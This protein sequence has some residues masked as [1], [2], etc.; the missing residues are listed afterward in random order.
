ML[1]PGSVLNDRYTIETLIAKGGMS[2]VYLASDS[3][4][5]G[6]IVVKEMGDIFP[7]AEDR[8]AIIGQFRRE[9]ALLSKLSHMSLPRV[10]D[11]FSIQ[12][13]HYLVEEHLEGVTLDKKA[14]LGLFSEEE[15]LGVAVQILSLLDFLH[16]H[17]IIYRDV[18]PHHIMACS[19]GTYRL[20][21]FGIARLFSIGKRRDTVL[22]GT[23]GFA[24]PEHYGQRQTDE[25]SDIYGMAATLHFLVTGKDS[26]LAPFHFDPPCIVN[27]AVSKWFSDI[28]MAGVELSPEDRFQSAREMLEVLSGPRDAPVRARNFCYPERLPVLRGK[29]GVCSVLFGFV[30]A[31]FLSSAIIEGNLAFIGVSL[32]SAAVSYGYLT[33]NLEKRRT[34]IVA[35]LRDLTLSRSG[36]NAFRT[37]IPWES[38]K[39]LRICRA[40]RWAGALR[41]IVS[42]GKEA[43]QS[44]AISRIEILYTIEEAGTSSERIYTSLSHASFD[45]AALL[46][47]G[48]I[49]KLSF[50]S[51]LEGW[52]EL[53]RFI[54]ARAKL[55]NADAPGSDV[56][57]EVYLR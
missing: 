2:L 22:M 32:F 21:D 41:K 4:L 56:L 36:Y 18:K 13:S 42:R 23:P 27:E 46:E 40:Q 24:A 49:K 20:V 10:I 3:H 43:R 57:D 50:T 11:S 16:S 14:A 1:L 48:W 29:R 25:R 8:E 6:K 7:S 51:E 38:I 17:R 39:A 19:D 5:P 35:S 30:S 54:R 9:A 12:E 47:K 26:A 31:S 52:E 33:E 55:R 37:V 53:T 44:I 45:D 28:I 34:R 15:A